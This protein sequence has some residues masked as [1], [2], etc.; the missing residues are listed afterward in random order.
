MH[1]E[2]ICIFRS[3]LSQKNVDSLVEDEQYVQI[4]DKLQ[5]QNLENRNEG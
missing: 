3:Y 2:T 5:Q 1:V 4:K